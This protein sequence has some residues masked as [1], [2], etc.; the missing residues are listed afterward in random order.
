MTTTTES[1]EQK[2]ESA[3]ERLVRAHLTECESAATKAVRAGF[4]RAA[5]SS[6]KASSPKSKPGRSASRRRTRDEIAAL[7][8]RLFAAICA[9]P[10][11]TM[12]VIAPAVGA[13]PR[14]LNRPATLL[15]RSGRVRSVGQRQYTRYFPMDE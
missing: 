4:V 8:E 14:E 1:L 3:V 2:I 13:K 11:E 12:A 10:G 5:R 7:E 6:T 15:R 9:H